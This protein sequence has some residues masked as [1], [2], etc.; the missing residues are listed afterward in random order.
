MPR[1]RLTTV[2]PG[3]ATPRAVEK[4]QS[5]RAPSRPAGPASGLLT[6]SGEF[7]PHGLHRFRFCGTKDNR[8]G[9]FRT[10]VRAK[11]NTID[12]E[13]LRSLIAAADGFACSKCPH[14]GTSYEWEATQFVALSSHQPSDYVAPDNNWE[15]LYCLRTPHTPPNC[16]QRASDA[17]TAS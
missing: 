4:R 14:P 11:H 15:I 12:H 3:Q 10:F 16:V 8:T 7:R 13:T 5:P 6:L 2:A 17:R 1:I 9:S